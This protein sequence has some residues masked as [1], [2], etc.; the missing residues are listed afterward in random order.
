MAWGW[1]PTIDA[2]RATLRS[3]L[4]CG[5]C[6]FLRTWVML[7]QAESRMRSAKASR[8]LTPYCRDRGTEVQ[9][10]ACASVQRAQNPATFS[11]YSPR[12]V[13]AY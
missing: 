6:L 9:A 3:L 2:P 11:G 5:G 4:I 10:P 8:L 7:V 12:F 13:R 1:R